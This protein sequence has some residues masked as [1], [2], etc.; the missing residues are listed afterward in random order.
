MTNDFDREVEELGKVI[1]RLRED[2]PDLF[3]TPEDNMSIDELAESLEVLERTIKELGLTA[4][5]ASASVV[6]MSKELNAAMEETFPAWSLDY[7]V[8]FVARDDNVF[9]RNLRWPERLLARLLDASLSERL[10]E[11][12]SE[13]LYIAIWRIT[14]RVFD[15]YD[16]REHGEDGS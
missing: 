5:Y 11:P 16:K 10:P 3:V 13:W 15:F 4:S 2:W 14:E 9:I 8:A 1:D 12:V 7:P 6:D